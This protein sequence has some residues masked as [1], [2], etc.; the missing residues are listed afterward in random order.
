MT[1]WLLLPKEINTYKSFTLCSLSD[2]L[3]F[4]V[5]RKNSN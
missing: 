1:L 4:I 2:S 5:L 3:I